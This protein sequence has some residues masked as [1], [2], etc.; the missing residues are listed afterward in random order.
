MPVYEVRCVHAECGALNRVP[1]YSVRKQPRCG[2]CNNLL[3]ES[4]HTKALRRIY[5]YGLY[6]AR[7]ALLAAPIGLFAW[8]GSGRETPSAMPP[9][10]NPRPATVCGGDALPRQ[11]D[12]AILDFAPRVAP[13]KVETSPNSYYLVKLENL[14]NKY[15]SLSFFLHGGMPFQ[16][17][18]PLGTY[19]LKYAMGPTWCGPRELFGPHATAKKARTLLFFQFVGDRYEGH[20]VTLF[21]VPRGNFQ[22]DSISL[23]EF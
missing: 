9:K 11:G 4:K 16:T 5:Q 13:F 7:L 10:T 22:T 3:P 2:K 8:V 20:L 17:D 19:L 6:V 15:S 1:E 21:R 18:V 23:S 12:Y 14:Q